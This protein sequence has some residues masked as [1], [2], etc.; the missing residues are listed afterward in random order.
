MFHRHKWKEISRLLGTASNIWI[1]GEF[2]KGPI[3]ITVVTLRCSKVGCAGFKQIT[4][5]GHVGKTDGIPE[6][7]KEAFG[8]GEK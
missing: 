1:N 4:L 8:E 6:V 5:L 7:Y 3:E 2:F